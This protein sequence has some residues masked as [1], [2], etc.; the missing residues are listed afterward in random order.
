MKVA[1][2]GIGKLYENMVRKLKHKHVSL[3]YLLYIEVEMSSKQLD[4]Y[5]VDS[6]GEIQTRIFGA[7]KYLK[8]WDGTYLYWFSIA[9]IEI[10][11]NIVA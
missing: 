11:T 1:F 3:K 9:A 4:I 8:S 5:N 6:F 10:T 2:I 7:V